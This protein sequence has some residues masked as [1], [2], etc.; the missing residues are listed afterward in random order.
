MPIFMPCGPEVH[1]VAAGVIG[2]YFPRLAEC[3]AR[4]EYL[5]A[6]PTGDTPPLM[7]DGFPCAAVAKVLSAED[8]ADGAF[9][10]RVKIDGRRWATL[11]PARREALLAHELYH[12]EP[13][14]KDGRFVVDDRGRPV[15][16]IRPHDWEVKGFAEVARWYGE[17]SFEVGAIRRLSERLRQ[18]ELPF[19]DGPGASPLR[20]ATS[21]LAETAGRFVASPAPEGVIGRV[22][23]E[24]CP[25]DSPAP[26]PAPAPRLLGDGPGSVVVFR[27]D[28]PEPAPKAVKAPKTPKGPGTPKGPKGPKPV[29]AAEA[30]TRA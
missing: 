9:E 28:E 11:E 3:G 22:V 19:G 4:V 24:P 5:F 23:G 15:L 30:S 29:P 14:M 1:E 12:F 10:A 8:R 26:A 17:S 18:V 13:V 6:F 27:S 25:D 20:S 21:E 7:K 16:K 2:E